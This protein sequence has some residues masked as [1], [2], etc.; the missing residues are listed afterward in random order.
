[1]T[2]AK[3]KNKIDMKKSILFSP[4]IITLLFTLGFYNIG[5]VSAK[6][7]DWNHEIIY[8]VFQRSF[9]D[10]NGDRN[11]DI[12]GVIK[13]LDYLKE[14]GITTIMFTPLYESDFYHNYF[15][16]DYDKIDPEYGTMG[17]YLALIKAIHKNGMKFIM[18]METQYA[19]NG[20][21]WFDDSYKNPNSKYSDYIFYSDSLN[22]NPQQFF[23]PSGSDLVFSK[24]WPNQNLNIVYLNLNSEKVKD[25][26]KNFYAHWVDPNSDGKFD[27]GVDGFRIDHM[28]DDLDNMGIFTNMFVNFWNPVFQ[29]CKTINPKLFVVGE[30]SNW[31]EYGNDM[32]DRG[33]ID[34]SFGFPIQ[35]AI[36]GTPE[37][38]MRNSTDSTIK[39][40]LN[41]NHI[42][43]QVSQTLQRIPQSKY[44]ISFLEN[45]DTDRFASVVNNDKRKMACGAI[46]NLLLPGIPS[47]YYG[48]ELGVAGQIGNWGFDANHIPVREAFPWTPNPDDP[49]T[50]VF[51]KGT[52]PWWDQSYFKTGES[53]KIAL[54]AE[55]NDP[56]SLWN[57][58]RRLIHFRKTN[59]AV[60][61][62]SFEIVPTENP[63]ILAF[64]RESGDEKV[65]VMLNLSEKTTTIKLP[66]R[67]KYQF[68]EKIRIKGDHLIFQPYGYVIYK[69]DI[70]SVK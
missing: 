39:L 27:D 13:K 26:T 70:Q 21:I 60:M 24:A 44:Y 2:E 61:D 12:N 20:N 32:I 53:K 5:S 64:S 47:I 45:H 28:M 49:G 54:S 57:L 23:V 69:N 55:Q 50:S 16:L 18:D 11:G 14:L 19:Q 67:R 4:V 30:Q 58:Y 62:G 40:G 63:D 46:I 34:A 8:H 65:V 7:P 22:R 25:W 52:G 9:Y 38:F 42:G 37:Y 68:Q 41:A 43:K 56:A 35:F 29:Y 6:E 17:D 10:S 66:S 15:A 1:M 48:Q 33:G 31:A 36:A 51:Y 3:N 59:N